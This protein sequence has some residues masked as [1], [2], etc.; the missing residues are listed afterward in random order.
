MLFAVLGW[1]VTGHP[2]SRIDELGKFAFAKNL[3]LAIALT[4]SGYGLVLSLIG[5][6]TVVAA[7]ALHLPVRIPLVIVASQ[8]LSQAV[9]NMLKGLYAR[10]RPDA[11]LYRHEPGYS[12]PSGHATTA[13]VFYGAWLLVLWSAPLPLTARVAGVALLLGWGM[14][15][16]WSRVALG[17]HYPSDVAGGFLFG[18]GWLCLGLALLRVELVARHVTAGPASSQGVAVQTNTF[19][20]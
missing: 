9:V 5:A 3:P 19:R 17:A 14:G 10:H 11:W 8:L 4:D 7:L 2:L 13:V 20:Q 12:Y 1:W 15:I 18:L 6:G 16:G